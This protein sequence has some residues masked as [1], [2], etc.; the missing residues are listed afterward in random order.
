MKAK[1]PEFEA[2]KEKLKGTQ[3]A[4]LTRW[5][6]DPLAFVQGVLGFALVYLGHPY[7]GVF[8]V[9]LRFQVRNN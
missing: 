3:R 1:M 5:T 8:I 6:F 2:H 9:T 4:E 7:I